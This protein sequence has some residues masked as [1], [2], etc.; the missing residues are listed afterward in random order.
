MLH[1]EAAEKFINETA[2]P[3]EKAVYDVLYN[4]QPIDTALMEL[5]KFQNEDGGFGHGLEADNWNP[6]S[7]PIAT[8]DAIIWIYRMNAFSSAKYIVEGIVRYLE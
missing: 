8:N 2:R 1:R 7:N 6:N 4:N 5:R 3:F